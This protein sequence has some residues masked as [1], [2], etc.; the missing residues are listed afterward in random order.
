MACYH[1]AGHCLAR[2][3]FGRQFDRAVVLTRDEVRQGVTI[4]NRRGVPVANIEGFMDGYE[5]LSSFMSPDLLARTGGDPAEVAHLQAQTWGAVEV[6]LTELYAGPAAEARQRRMSL[7]AV[8]ITGGQGDYA[9]S[10]RTLDIW[11]PSRE[12]RAA[13]ALLAEQ[14]APALVR[15]IAG[16][17]A[18]TAMARHLQENGELS[19]EEGNAF[20]EKAYGWSWNFRGHA[21]PNDLPTAAEIRRGLEPATPSSQRVDNVRVREGRSGAMFI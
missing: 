13:A 3:Y 17:T 8:A 20:C 9:K 11:H 4:E 14:R 6:E 21:I 5:V 16:W 18:I 1:E 2:W 15:S 7:I 19:W 10:T 12:T